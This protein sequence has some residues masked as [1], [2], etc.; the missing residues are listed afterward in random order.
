MSTK[1][2][3]GIVV[4]I[5]ILLAI[6][7]LL[8]GGDNKPEIP[9]TGQPEVIE[10]VPANDTMDVTQDLNTLTIRFD[11]ESTSDS[12]SLRVLLTALSY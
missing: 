4:V 7:L 6:P 8:G 11:S 3:I 9:Y 10:L 12:Q 2:V 1:A 5:A